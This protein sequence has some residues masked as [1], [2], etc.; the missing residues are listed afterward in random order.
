MGP[1]SVPHSL[2]AVP[3]G[4]RRYLHGE[5][6]FDRFAMLC[7]ALVWGFNLLATAES[8]VW[9]LPWWS[10]VGFASTFLIS[11]Y[12]DRPTARENATFAFAVYQLSAFRAPRPIAYQVR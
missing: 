6:M 5:H 2:T 1:S 10:M 12:N 11:A 9:A 7:A 3:G 8:L 4:P